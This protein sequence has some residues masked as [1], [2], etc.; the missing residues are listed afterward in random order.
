M[1]KKGIIWGIVALL[2]LGGIYYYLALPAI[3]IHSVE[4]WYFLLYLVAA[5]GVIYVIVSAINAVKR[6]KRVEEIRSSKTL[7]KIVM[8][9]G[10]LVIVFIGG[11]IL[12]S[13]IVNAKKYQSLLTV[14]DG[15]FTKDIEELSFDQIPILDRD[16][17]EI[18]G[19]RKMGSMSDMVSQFEVDDIYSQINYQDRPVRVSPVKYASLV[20]WFTNRK[21]G[22]PAYIMI[23]M[24][25]QTTRLV[26]LEEGMK[27]STSEHFGRNIYRHLRFSYPTYI[28]DEMSFEID[29]D[30]TPYWV[31][32]VV[33]YN[34]GLF[35]G[36]TVGRVVLCNAITG[37]TTDY[38]IDEVPQWIDHAYSASLLIELYDY[39]GSLKHGFI[40]SVLSQKD[41]LKTTNGYNYLAIDDDVWVYTGVTS[42]NSDQ[43]NVGFVLMN[44]RTMETK[45]YKVEGAI[46]DSA[47]DSAE[48]QVQNLHYTATFPL[49]LNI[50]GEP[51]YFIAL[52]D[53][54]GL[55]KKY[56]LVNV[57]KYQL[58]AIGDT[59]SQCEESYNSLLLTNGV[60]QEETDTRE[61]QTVKGMITKI[62]QGVVDG[63]SHYYI[64]LDNSKD[65]FDVS[66]VDYIEIIKYDVGD[67]VT[68]EYK[69]GTKANT[70]L[71]VK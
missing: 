23:D 68:L 41:C 27:Y 38:A 9:F 31:A 57:Q 52:K 61:I 13:P 44:E 20:K 71:S 45:Y 24:A 15:E 36:R 19:D 66:V 3:N 21:E 60:K 50:A 70:V 7:K 10:I 22:L 63:N 17:A 4:V 30:G 34:I 67:E 25:S 43:S 47:M 16:S 33:K 48:G 2:V 1:K 11:S 62:A 51:T 64:M 28:F 53:D 14:E 12:S 46:E 56:A 40:N 18:L 49:L 32:P 8:V 54:A 29:E 69:E 35:G 26:K 65:I 37:E 6:G 5:I 58:V 39:Y 59:V 55:V 42:V